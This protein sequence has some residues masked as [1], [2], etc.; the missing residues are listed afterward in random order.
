MVAAVVTGLVCSTMAAA[1]TWCSPAPD[2]VPDVGCCLQASCQ[3]AELQ[4]TGMASR[5]PSACTAENCACV[6]DAVMTG[7]V[8]S[9]V[10]GP[11]CVRSRL[12]PA[13]RV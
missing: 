3:S 9:T 13:R 7:L 10:A 11:D 4:S 8:C 12:L 1:E 5:R 6:I 2:P